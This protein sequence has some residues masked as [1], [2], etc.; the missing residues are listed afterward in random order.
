MALASMQSDYTDS[1]LV[2]L[3]LM[4]DELAIRLIIR[5]YNQRLYRLARGITGNNAEAEDVVQ[6]AYLHAFKN[7]GQFR[8]EASLCTWLG[9]IVIN[10]ALMTM[11]AKRRVKRLPIAAPRNTQAQIIAF[12]LNITEDDPERIIAQRQI[13]QLIE[14][15]TDA[16]PE[17]YRI[18][19]V[20]R[21]IEGLSEEQTAAVLCLPVNTVKS[22]LYRARKLI[23]EQLEAKI[24]PVFMDAFP[25]AGQRCGRLTDVVIN[26]LGF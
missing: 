4:R 14:Q 20:A 17:C 11:R 9:R 23:K 1:E 6:E 7:L 25:F 18:V 21:I 24:G 5:T 12:P 2:D 3:A 13:L 8:G 19:F 26:K 22:R 10:I 16:L 15:S